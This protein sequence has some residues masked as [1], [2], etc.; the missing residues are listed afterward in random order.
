[1]GMAVLPER[2]VKDSRPVRCTAHYCI[3]RVGAGPTG[4]KHWMIIADR[5]TR[6]GLLR[7]IKRLLSYEQKNWVRRWN[8]RIK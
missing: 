7:P 5:C 1:M 3:E 8:R 4:R 6:C 2:P